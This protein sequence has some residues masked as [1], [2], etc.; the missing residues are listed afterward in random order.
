MQAPHPHPWIHQP[1]LT[2]GDL[3]AVRVDHTSIIGDH[4][5]EFLMLQS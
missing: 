2:G 3:C 1:P 4:K 5:D